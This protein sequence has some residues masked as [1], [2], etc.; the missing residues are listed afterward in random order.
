[1]AQS[2][3]AALQTMI[4]NLATKTGKSLSDWVAVVNKSGLAKHGEIV[5]KLKNDHGVGHG[6]ANLIAHQALDPTRCPW[7]GAAWIW[8]RSSTRVPRPACARSTTCW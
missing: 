2:P 8:S 7:P 3:E 6:Y 5:A 1:M 4:D